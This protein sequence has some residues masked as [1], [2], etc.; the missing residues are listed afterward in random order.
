LTD[1]SLHRLHEKGHGFGMALLPRT[2]GGLRNQ[3]IFRS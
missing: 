2:S 3:L 1:Y